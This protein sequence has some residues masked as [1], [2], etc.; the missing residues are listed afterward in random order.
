VTGT[1]DVMWSGFALIPHNLFSCS[2]FYP[3]CP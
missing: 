1:A 3:N 2:P